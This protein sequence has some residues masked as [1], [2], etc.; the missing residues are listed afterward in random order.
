MVCWASFVTL[1]V[2][3]VPAGFLE[4]GYCLWVFEFRRLGYSHVCK[5]V[6]SGVVVWCVGADPL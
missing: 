2:M 6:E 5:G 3:V 4:L 1:V